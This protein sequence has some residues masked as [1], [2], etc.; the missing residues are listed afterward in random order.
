MAANRL[1]G[2][3]FTAM[4]LRIVDPYDPVLDDD[5]GEQVKIGPRFFADAPVILDLQDCH[6]CL[7]LEDFTALKAMLHKHQLIAIGIQNASAAQQRVA[8][9]ADLLPFGRADGAT[10]RTAGKAAGSS[11]AETPPVN[12]TRIVTKP[13]RSGTQIYVR[14]GD[15]VVVA[16][17]SAGAEIIADGHIHVYGPLRGR[18]IAGAAGDTS[19]RIFVH[20][21]EAELVCIAGRYLVSDAIPREHHRQSAQIALIEDEL[22]ILRGDWNESAGAG[23]ESGTKQPVS[24]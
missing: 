23:E 20:R 21:L 5:I 8:F 6:G 11:G 2:G 19:A 9:T 13:V 24:A 4:V 17:V 12:K 22:C 1:Q 7:A 10:K 16:P 15:L 14:G 18:A 3:M